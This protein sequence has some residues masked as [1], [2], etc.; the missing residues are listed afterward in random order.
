M[1]ETAP[2]DT[3]TEAP[4]EV[5]P[6]TATE[7]T[8]AALPVPTRRLRSELNLEQWPIWVP[9]RSKHNAAPRTLTREIVGENGQKVTAEVAIAVSPKGSLTTEDQRTYYALVDHHQRNDP[10]DGLMYFSLRGLA[11][12][13]AKPWGSRTIETLTDSLIRLR[14]NTLG[15][16][17]SYYD[18][19]TGKAQEELGFFNIITDLK[20]I[21]AKH[22]GHVTR[23]EGYF[24]LNDAIIANLERNYTKPV[25]L[26]VVL[27]FQSEIA[28]IL[29]TQID[30][31]L[32]KDITVYESRTKE[33]FANLG[34]EGKKYG[35]PSGRKQV[36]ETAIVEFQDAPLT[37]GLAIRS[38]TLEKTADDKDYKLVV[39]R[40]RARRP[41][42]TTETV[43]SEDQAEPPHSKKQAGEGRISQQ[44]TIPVET[45]KGTDLLAYF[46]LVFFGTET[47]TTPPGL[48]HRNLADWMIASHGEEMSRYIVDFAKTE[49][50]KTNFRIA[51]FGAI[52]N[53]V[54]RAVAH[55]TLEQAEAKRQEEAR[56]EAA[57]QTEIDRE[58]VAREQRGYQLFR[59]LSDDDRN[60][61][62]GEAR[63]LLITSE[64]WRNTDF[65]NDLFKMM[66]EKESEEKVRQDLLHLPAI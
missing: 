46:H 56:R 16:K 51:T 60:A 44:V 25:L 66:F 14:M 54:D 59:E 40:G 36:L 49:A 29:Y 34:L 28:Q 23:A 2:A 10:R 22:D 13:L 48:K 3:A 21:T 1:N 32:S 15:W 12:S 26:D 43:F 41:Q 64:K 58:R 9:A 50:E 37:N 47:V 35:Q 7:A 19:A 27:G 55:H 39:R 5:R 17:N 62:M 18:A 65:S 33:L 30:R 31:I 6:A 45:G 11:K 63:A 61:L 53:Y 20:V 8:D 42:A 4:D 24:K 38:V 52:A 57:R